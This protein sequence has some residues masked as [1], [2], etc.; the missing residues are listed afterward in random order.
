MLETI[1]RAIQDELDPQEA[2]DLTARLIQFPTENPPGDVSEAVAFVEQYLAQRGIESR[3][4]APRPGK[5]NLLARIKGNRPGPTL[6]LNGHIDVVPSGTRDGWAWDPYGGEIRD[7]YILGRG[8]TDMKG[9]LAGLITAFV[10]AS[11]V[12]DLPGE[13]VL[14]VVCDEETGGREGTQWLLETGQVTG[15]GCIIGEPSRQQP[16]IGQKGACWLRLSTRGVPAHGSLSPIIGN[17]AIRTMAEAVETVYRIFDRQWPMPPE[18]AEVVRRSQESLVKERGI[19]ELAQVFER[20]T[21]NA[22]VIR[23][24]DKINMV[25]DRCEAEI[26]MRVPWGTRSEEVVAHLRE[27]LQARGLEVEIESL[28]W[29]SEPNYT[30]PSEPVVQSVLWGIRQVSGAEVSPVFQYA[31]SDA[32]HFRTHG[33]P[34]IQCGPGELDG[35]HGYNE[36]VAVQDVIQF[37][38][39]YGAAI[40]GF[41][42]GSGQRG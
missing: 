35:I 38:Q 27:M 40:A 2:V 36:R 15:D 16:T 7:G 31:S 14:T 18:I 28:R 30:L 25:A 10:A 1:Y 32:R 33:I 6:I 13:L 26:D 8:A 42:T 19:P 34:T 11:R 20:V 39:V 21:V 23:G 17:S 22:G 5:V 3:I 4:L 24:G 9:G 29:R 41:L 37:T 12:R